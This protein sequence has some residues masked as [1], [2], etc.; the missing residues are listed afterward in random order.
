MGIMNFDIEF[1]NPKLL[2]LLIVPA[3]MIVWYIYKNASISA[4]MQI[5]TTNIPA[6]KR[7]TFRHYLRHILF[8]IEIL[9]IASLILA[10]ARPQSTKSWEESETKGIDIVI[11]LD[12][13]SSMEL[14][15]FKPSRLE[16]AKNVAI[17]FISGRKFDEIGL[18]VF[19]G[20]SYTQCPLTTDYKVLINLFKKVKSGIIEDK[21]AIGLGLATAIKRLKDSEAKSKVIILLT[22]GKNNTGEIGPITAAEIAKE[23]NIRVYTIG[24][25]S[26]DEIPI[27]VETIFG[28]QTQY[29]KAE[30]DEETLKQIAD[31]TDGAYFRATN[32]D[33]LK[34]IYEKIDALEKSK[35]QVQQYTKPQEKFLL[36]AIIGISALCLDYLM[37]KLFLKTIP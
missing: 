17:E 16:A 18:V 22:D 37:R 33:K 15:D 3:G 27:Q 9:G 19:A 12:V 10:L 14:P 4:N 11:A 13:S 30:L 24:V 21:T 20:E 28:K 36:F 35:I 7:K 23:F 31:I 34:E 1:L 8:G 32:K 2:F 6:L 29:V 5:S 26:N 25:G